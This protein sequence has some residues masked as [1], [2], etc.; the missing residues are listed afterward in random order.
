[1]KAIYSIISLLSVPA[2]MATAQAADV[3]AAL[4][5]YD[6]PT[7]NQAKLGYA[8]N[9]A[10]TKEFIAMQT[11]VVEKLQTLSSE[12]IQ[13]FM[14]KYDPAMLIPYDP[15]LWESNDAY[16]EYKKEWNKTQMQGQAQVA[17]SL[18]TAGEGTW[19]FFAV[20]ADASGRE[21]PVT[22][23]ALT[24]N[25]INNTWSS[26][27]GELTPSEFKATDDFIF[28]AQ[29]GTEWKLEK[30]DSFVK[31]VQSLRITKSTDGKSVFVAFASVERD[32][33]TNQTL[34]QQ[35]YTLL[36]PVQQAQMNIG[37]PGSK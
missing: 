24:Y 12:K 5:G 23:S 26:A 14:E 9:P 4:A 3:P 15:E 13:A 19:R 33:T 21:L 28:K 1:M 29:S 18:R 17:I 27:H 2:L 34:S 37:K 25:P 22:I 30:Q 31:T 8:I 36:F 6:F 7:G 35:G 16:N 32:R 20:T 10:F 11:K